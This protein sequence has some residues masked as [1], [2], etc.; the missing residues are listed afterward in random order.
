MFLQWSLF[1]ATTLILYVLVGIS[2]TVA[3]MYTA[4]SSDLKKIGAYL[5]ILHMNLGI[6]VLAS[7][8]Q[9]SSLTSDML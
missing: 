4:I 5:S 6:Y 2:V 8:G 9:L 1:T 3:T 7:S